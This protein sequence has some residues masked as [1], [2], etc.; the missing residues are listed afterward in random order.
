MESSKKYSRDTESGRG[1]EKDT[2]LVIQLTNCFVRNSENMDTQG[3]SS[4][5][6]LNSLVGS[7]SLDPS[8]FSIPVDT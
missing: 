8:G 1:K 3:E 2:V 6:L 5:S 4:L 7:T